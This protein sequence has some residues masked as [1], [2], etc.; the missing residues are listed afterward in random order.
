MLHCM[1]DAM[2]RTR[3]PFRCTPGTHHFFCMGSRKALGSLHPERGNSA[4]TATPGRR[5]APPPPWRPPANDQG[6][7]WPKRKARQ[8]KTRKQS[9]KPRGLVCT[10]KQA[11]EALSRDPSNQAPGADKG[12]PSYKAPRRCLARASP[13]PSWL[14]GHGPLGREGGKLVL[15]TS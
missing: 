14:V 12:A 1:L 10:S 15:A 5:L 6:L 13:L 4:R 11:L 9:R 3:V 2:Q 7:N 8:N